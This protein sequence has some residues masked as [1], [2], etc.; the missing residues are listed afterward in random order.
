MKLKGTMVIELTDVDTGEVQTYTEENM[1]TNVI[2]NI[3]GTNPMGIMYKTSGEYD[4]MVTWNDNLLPI[5]PNMIGGILLYSEALEEDVDNLYCDSSHLPVAYASNDVNSTTDLARGSLNLTESYALDNGYKFVW[6]FTAS[7]GNG[8]I[9]AVALTSALG[10]RFAY[11][12]A[13]GD[14][15][16]LLEIREVDI[17][18]MSLA[19]KMLLF[20]IEE[21]DFENE[22]AYSLTY[23]NSSVVIRKLR[24]PVFTIGLNERLD[25][26]TY[27]LLEE[28]AVT[29][30]TFSFYGTSKMYGEFMDGKDGYWYGF[31]NDSGNYSGDA[32]MRWVKISK[33]DYSIEEGT[34]TL[35]DATLY[36]V[37]TRTENSSYAM[38][39][40]N[41]CVRN[42][43]L[44]VMSYNYD[45]VYKINIANSADVT[46]IDLGFT[47]NFRSVGATGSCSLKMMLIGDLIVGYD[48]Q[49]TADDTVIAT[50]GGQKL[51][52]GA[53]QLFQYKN[54]LIGWGG[55][56]G[57]EGKY[58]YLLTPYH[59][60]INNL[61]S[62]VT[63][64]SS[65]TMK[66]TY[67]LT[68]ADSE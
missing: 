17:S 53:S 64:D 28:K 33:T 67:T 13:A 39:D 12:S 1:V 8:T 61:D 21:V 45:G 48:F 63:K 26:T 52:Y 68:E 56:Y 49:I 34:W 36:A 37:G 18:N 24:L 46:L 14:T 3:L 30:S 22:V 35:S 62:A 44:Y 20:E 27:T 16:T 55:S 11:G 5:C 51:V 54:F 6:E 7:Q 19:D 40:V 60:T 59:A 38:R 4:D 57:N 65:M 15:S 47:S 9:A 10:G 50:A 58:A 66:I 31:S 32:T 29:V 41:S 2:N 25:D 23:S 43:Y 42:G